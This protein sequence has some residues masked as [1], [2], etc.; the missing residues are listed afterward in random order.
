[1]NATAKRAIREWL[2]VPPETDS[3][4]LF[5]QENGTALSKDGVRSVWRRVAR[6]SGVQLM[7]GWA[8]PAVVPR[9]ADEVAQETAAAKLVEYAPIWR[10]NSVASYNPLLWSWKLRCFR[11][12]AGSQPRQRN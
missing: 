11:K 9:Y 7:M 2:R 8:N 5:V 12:F 10:A 4:Q 1:M 6:K 3:P